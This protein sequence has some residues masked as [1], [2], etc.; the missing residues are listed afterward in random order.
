[1]NKQTISSQ[2]PPH[3]HHHDHRFVTTATTSHNHHSTTANHPN[4][5]DNMATPH[6]QPNRQMTMTWHINGRAT[7][8]RQ[9]WRTSS[10][11]ILIKVSSIPPLPLFF[12]HM[13]SRGHHTTITMT[14]ST[15]SSLP[16]P[17]PPQQ[18]WQCGNATSPAQWTNNDD[19]WRQP[20]TSTDMPHCPDGDGTRCHC[21]Y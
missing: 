16:P 18:W 14:T 13:R 8:S 19:G 15:L 11:F 5:N 20:G 17:K 6:H 7:S 4:N 2:P 10:L 1:M 21:S 12:S 3:H 9:W